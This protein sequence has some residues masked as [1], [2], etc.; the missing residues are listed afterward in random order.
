MFWLKS[1]MHDGY[2]VHSSPLRGIEADAGSLGLAA[3]RVQRQG[4]GRK[5]AAGNDKTL[6][7]DPQKILEFAARGDPE[8]PLL[9][10]AKSV[11]QL[12][13]DLQQMKHTVSHQVVADL[14]HE[15]GHSLQANR[16]TREAA[17]ALV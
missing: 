10:T 2:Q 5:R 7:S 9:W 3:G 8:T 1:W 15:L 14:L 6:R 4:G 12:T 11:R 17:A 16:K 13:A